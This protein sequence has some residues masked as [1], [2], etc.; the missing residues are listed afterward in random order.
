MSGVPSQ[1]CEQLRVCELIRRMD[2]FIT[3]C[4]ST[5]CPFTWTDTADSV[6]PKVERRARAINGTS[7]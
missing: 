6:L 4:N 7:H 2:T 3:R 5:A 1:H